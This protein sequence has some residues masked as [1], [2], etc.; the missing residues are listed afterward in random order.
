[1]NVYKPFLIRI[2]AVNLQEI[3]EITKPATAFVYSRQRIAEAKNLQRL[4]WL[5][6]WML[7]GCKKNEAGKSGTNE[8]LHWGR[9]LIRFVKS[10]S[11]TSHMKLRK[12][13]SSV[14][15]Q[16]SKL[17]CIS[18]RYTKQVPSEQKQVGVTHL[19]RCTYL[20]LSMPLYRSTRQKGTL[21]YIFEML[22]N[23]VLLAWG[24]ISHL[25]TDIEPE[26]K[27]DTEQLLSLTLTWFPCTGRKAKFV[28][29]FIQRL[30][31]G[32]E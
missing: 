2:L 5:G 32:N 31:K 14:S 4:A 8:K 19:H 7:K 29:I 12:K 22:S 17:C 11:R 25:C 26:R 3:D 23:A 20:H 21:S 15:S 6:I 10:S 24:N 28:K 18:C 27:V 30:G 16:K 13:L 1:M 9:D